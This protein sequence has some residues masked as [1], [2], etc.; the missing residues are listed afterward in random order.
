MR[1]ILLVFFFAF[2][3]SSNSF[4]GGGWKRVTSS[5]FSNC[6]SPGDVVKFPHS[7]LLSICGGIKFTSGGV[8]HTAI[9]ITTCGYK[10]SQW[11]LTSGTKSVVGGGLSAQYGCPA[12]QNLEGGK[13]IPDDFCSSSAW[14][15]LVA[16]ESNACAAQYPD[17]LT[18]FSST[19]VNKNDYSFTCKQGIPKPP[20]GGDG[21][22]GGDGSGGSGGDGSGGSGGDGSGGSGGDGSGGDGS[23]G[24]GSGGDGSGGDGSG[25]DGSGGDG[26]GGDG[27]GGDGSGGDGSGGDGS[28][29]AFME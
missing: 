11:C 2:L 24:D 15:E 1:L 28:G 21:G 9:R 29:R 19:C 10:D 5:S 7:G 3:F 12:G 14:N 13:C 17:F 27:S 22:S 25:G 8:E 16:T 26:S 20:T 4:A 18:D 6:L 23:G